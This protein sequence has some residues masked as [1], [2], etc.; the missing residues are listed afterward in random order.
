ML[1]NVLSFCIGFCSIYSAWGSQAKSRSF[2]LQG[3]RWISTSLSHRR[4]GKIGPRMRPH[5]ALGVWF[6]S[7]LVYSWNIYV[8]CTKS[9]VLQFC[10]K[11]SFIPCFGSSL[12]SLLPQP[13]IFLWYREALWTRGARISGM[14]TVYVKLSLNYWACVVW[15][16]NLFWLSWHSRVL[17]YGGITLIMLRSMISQWHNVH[18]PAS[19]KWG[20]CSSVLLLQGGYM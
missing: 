15:S 5:W 4:C 16:A 18:H 20:I 2:T 13:R 3:R 8:V 10:E 19:K 1:L 11:R 12:L 9:S 7:P 17:S 6:F 14:L